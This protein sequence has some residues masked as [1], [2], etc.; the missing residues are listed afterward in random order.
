MTATTKDV[1]PCNPR[2]W[3]KDRKRTTPLCESAAR[4]AL[5][6]AAPERSCKM[7]GA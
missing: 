2:H 4:G 7:E 6:N 3:T 5:E 1:D